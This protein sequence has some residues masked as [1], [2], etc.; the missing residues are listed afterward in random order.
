M[1][2]YANL[3]TL[4]VLFLW[5]VYFEYSSLPAWGQFHQHCMQEFFVW[6]CFALLFSSYVLALKFFGAKILAQKA[7]VKC[8]WNR[9]TG[10]NFIGMLYAAF[11]LYSFDKKHKHKLQVEKS[12]KTFFCAKKLLSKCWWNWILPVDNFTNRHRR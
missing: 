1:I 10:V 12:C 4:I 9:T 2:S 6:K 7:S 8:W 5:F 11:C 3:F